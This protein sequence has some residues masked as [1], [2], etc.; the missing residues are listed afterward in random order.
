M[1][2]TAAPA[3]VV[4]LALCCGGPGSADVLRP[5]TV[6]APSA[7]ALANPCAAA[8][9]RLGTPFGAAAQRLRV[10]IAHRCARKV[11][12]LCTRLRGGSAAVGANDSDEA[13]RPRVFDEESLERT[14]SEAEEGRESED[15]NIEGGEAGGKSRAVDMNAV[16]D[17]YFEDL[18]AEMKEELADD[19]DFWCG[20]PRGSPQHRLNQALWAACKAGDEAAVRPRPL[21]CAPAP[22]LTPAARGAG[23]AR[24]QRRR[25]S[26]RAG[27]RDDPQHRTALRGARGARAR[28]AHPPRRRRGPHPA[29]KLARPPAPCAARPCTPRVSA[30]PSL[31]ARRRAR[32]ALPLAR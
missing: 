3:G 16:V 23:L 29:H 14:V 2:H 25:G 30:H 32:P 8:A 13:F 21:P 15:E 4:L 7:T 24:A 31:P 5:R 1:R 11:A 9:R 19:T 28:R 27:P 6:V 12:L 20:P 22:R 10:C 26:Q 18:L 17:T